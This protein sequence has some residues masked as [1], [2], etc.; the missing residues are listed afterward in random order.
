VDT[1]IRTKKSPREDIIRREEKMEK[2]DVVAEEA[3][4][5][6]GSTDQRETLKTVTA[7]MNPNH[8]TTSTAKTNPQEE[9]GEDIEINLKGLKSITN[10]RTKMVKTTKSPRVA[11]GIADLRSTI[12]RMV[13]E[14][15]RARAATERSVKTAM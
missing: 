10:P 14:L 2:K 4:V 6:I 8:S 7:S 11:K 15:R 5:V 3:E 13:S 1:T 12:K 9:E